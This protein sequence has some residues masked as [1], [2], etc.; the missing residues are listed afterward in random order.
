MLIFFR[1]KSGEKIEAIG[2]GV[3]CVGT[4]LLAVAFWWS[5]RDTLITVKPDIPILLGF[6]ERMLTGRAMSDY[7]WEVNPPLTMIIMI[8]AVLIAHGFK[9]ALQDGFWLQTY[10]YIFM[11]SG[12]FAFYLKQ[13]D[14]IDRYEKLLCFFLFVLA[15]FSVPSFQFGDREHVVMMG[16]IPFMVYQG[17][18]LCRSSGDTGISGWLIL[19]LGSVAALIKPHYAILPCFM[20]MLRVA[21]YK[22]LREVF[23]PDFWLLTISSVIYAAVLYLFFWDY[24]TVIAPDIYAFYTIMGD[25]ELVLQNTVYTLVISVATYLPFLIFV[26]EKKH[27]ATLWM[28]FAGMLVTLLP[29]YVQQKG[30]DYHRVPYFFMAF[31]AYGFA[32]HY[33]LEGNLCK[34]YPKIISVVIAC[35][36][37]VLVM[38]TIR[39]M[40]LNMTTE[41][42]LKKTE[43]FQVFEDYCE[44]PCSYFMVNDTTLLIH[45]VPMLFEAHHATRLS[46]LWFM[47]PVIWDENNTN[48]RRY[49]ENDEEREA[50]RSKYMATLVED[51]EEFTPEIALIIDNPEAG[52]EGFN[53]VR[54]LTKAPDFR[55]LWEDYKFIGQRRFDLGDYLK[56]LETSQEQRKELVFDIYAR[57]DS[58]AY[59]K[60]LN[61]SPHDNGVHVK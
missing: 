48:S 8:P 1:D 37:I 35:G 16:V 56:H 40:F 26:S 42:E 54:F 38:G 31:F 12:A 9:I 14:F 27:S 55:A 29:Y 18:L 47:L 36:L 39:P 4:I 43:L 30:F 50:F 15:Q 53:V 59:R 25:P 32:L 28:L 13:V 19:I 49:F 46:A 24:V 11:L 5:F 61:Q 41:D 23:R 34:V 51:F 22:D 20:I 33:V 58:E 44:K 21:Y 17:G 10:G 52:E 60:Y 7:Y 57:Q 6:A 45:Q 2:V 3:L